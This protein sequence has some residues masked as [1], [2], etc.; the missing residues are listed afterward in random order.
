MIGKGLLKKVVAS[1][2]AAASAFVAVIAFGATI[3]CAL[4]LIVPT[5]AAAAITFGVFGIL[6]AL[7]A[8]IFLKPGSGHHDDGEEDEPES[9]AQKA[10]H[11]IRERPI[12]GAAGGLGILFFLLRN[13]ALA[14]IAASMITEKRMESRGYG[15]RRR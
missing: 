1:F 11:L 10:V 13:P 6:T 4:C 15:R 8:V 2:A 14:A 3:F 9:F 5:L 12:L 7:I